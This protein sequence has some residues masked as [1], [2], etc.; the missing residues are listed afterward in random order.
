MYRAVAVSFRGWLVAATGFGTGL[1]GLSNSGSPSKVTARAGA[2]DLDLEEPDPFFKALGAAFDGTWWLFIL[3]RNTFPFSITVW[4]SRRSERHGFAY[5]TILHY[6]TSYYILFHCVT[7]YYII[8]QYSTLHCITT[9]YIISH[10]ITC[11]DIRLDSIPFYY[12]LGVG[13]GL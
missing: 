10:H 8:L 3:K 13:L 7:M 11:Y 12:I 4:G 2:L 1:L 5:Y 9:N 6:I